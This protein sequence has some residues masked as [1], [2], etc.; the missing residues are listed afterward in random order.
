MPKIALPLS[1]LAAFLLSYSVVPNVPE[2]VHWY[3]RFATLWAGWELMREWREVD[4]LGSSGMGCVF[5]LAWLPIL[6]PLFGWLPSGSEFWVNFILMT[7]VSI[8][9]IPLFIHYRN[10]NPELKGTENWPELPE[11]EN[12]LA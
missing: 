7:G 6:G 8:V 3:A 2:F 4:R 5:Y 11:D 10:P 1:L 12:P 9:A